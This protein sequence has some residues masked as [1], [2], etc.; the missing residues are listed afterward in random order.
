[1]KLRRFT[2]LFLLAGVPFLT[3]AHEAEEANAVLAACVQKW[4]AIET[5]HETA[6]F[7][8]GR[9]DGM[10]FNIQMEY[11]YQKGG[12]RLIKTPRTHFYSTAESAVSYRPE[13]D[14]KTYLY[15]MPDEAADM[16]RQLG[17][18]EEF[19]PDKHW[20]FA[21]ADNRKYIVGRLLS[22]NEQKRRM[23]DEE[24]AGRRLNVV[25]REQVVYRYL[26]GKSQWLKY[27]IDPDTGLFVKTVSM[28]RP[29]WAEPE[30]PDPRKDQEWPTEIKDA[31]YV[32]GQ[33]TVNEPI[34]DDT[35]VF[36]PPPDSTELI[37]DEDIEV[38]PVPSEGELPDE[39]CFFCRKMHYSI[40]IPQAENG[41]SFFTQRWQIDAADALEIRF[42]PTMKV[43]NLTP[44]RYGIHF[45]NGALR[46]VRLSDGTVLH[47][48]DI[49][50]A[51]GRRNLNKRLPKWHYMRHPDGDY[52]VAEQIL[53]KRQKD[54]IYDSIDIK[55]AYLVGLP[56]T[57]GGNVWMQKTCPS[58]RQNTFIWSVSDDEDLLVEFRSS[59]LAVRDIQGN[60]LFNWTAKGRGV[61]NIKLIY[62]G[63]PC[64]VVQRKDT[65]TCYDL[66]YPVIMSKD[67]G[68][69]ICFPGSHTG[70][71]LTA[72]HLA[73]QENNMAGVKALLASG[74][75]V[76]VQDSLGM[77]PQ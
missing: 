33:Q 19:M 60:F 4:G 17:A 11:F 59:S 38:A 56:L 39:R 45:I 74:E 61:E 47:N 43:E 64:M 28:E 12:A 15:M 76:N 18:E 51:F 77:T 27:W 37:M 26:A 50:E 32:A 54:P 75:D 20:L 41:D 13:K 67:E 16:T 10:S 44:F 66:N 25:V 72:L 9:Q 65:L 55:S 48:L 49:P 3:S 58:G 53:Y 52:L 36:V 63:K 42:S 70:S 40:G 8:I 71:D 14:R 7:G 23:P 24:I 31:F 68:E 2:F 30:K 35:F 21:D 1:M 46:V 62:D 57:E 73:V 5:L 6:E 69:E 34:P 22:R 29:D